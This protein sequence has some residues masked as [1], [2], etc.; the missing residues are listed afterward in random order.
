[1]NNNNKH[2]NNDNNVDIGKKIFLSDTSLSMSFCVYV[3]LIYRSFVLNVFSARRE[4]TTK[5][6]IAYDI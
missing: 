1:M 6:T 4:L 2:P 3:Q 5:H